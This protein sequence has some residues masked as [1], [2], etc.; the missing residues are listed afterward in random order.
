MCWIQKQLHSE[1]HTTTALAALSAPLTWGGY[2]HGY[3][4]PEHTHSHKKTPTP[5]CTA[6][7]LRL[8]LHDC[9]ID[10]V[11]F[12]VMQVSGSWSVS[13][14]SF[15]DPVDQVYNLT[16]LNLSFTSLTTSQVDISLVYMTSDASETPSI[17]GIY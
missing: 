10:C 11:S 14:C 15:I 5:S 8:T 2:I 3:N 7:S 4:I 12:V 9:T 6:V 1:N 16:N 13:Q 17:R